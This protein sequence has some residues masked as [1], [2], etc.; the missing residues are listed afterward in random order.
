MIVHTASSSHLARSYVVRL[1]QPRRT[2]SANI[3]EGD[4]GKY[5]PPMPTQ[6]AFDD[7]DKELDAVFELLSQDTI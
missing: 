7:D 2:L 6:P 3:L 4:D 5:L 1:V